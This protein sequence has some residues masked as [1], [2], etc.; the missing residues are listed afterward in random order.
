VTFDRRSLMKYLILV[1]VIVILI[2]PGICLNRS[3]NS[4]PSNDVI[5][6]DPNIVQEPSLEFDNGPQHPSTRAN[7]VDETPFSNDWVEAV[8]KIE[9]QEP[10]FV[11]VETTFA[12]YEINLGTVYGNVT[13]ADI[14]IWAGGDPSSTVITYL[15]SHVEKN[16][17]SKFLEITFPNGDYNYQSSVVSQSSLDAAEVDDYQPPIDLS[18]SGYVIIDEHAYFS[19]SELNEYNIT[20]VNELIEG[21]LKMGAKITQTLKLGAKAGHY[22]EFEISVPRYSLYQHPDQLTISHPKDEDKESDYLVVKRIDNKDGNQSEFEYLHDI[23]LRASN[24]TPALKTGVK[25]EVYIQLELDV[26]NFNE[27]YLRDSILEISVVDLREST[28]ELPQNITELYFMSSDGIRLFYE[29]GVI[30]E[31]DIQDEI[32][33]ELTKT[34]D[35]LEEKLNSTN[36]IDLE[37]VKRELLLQEELE[38]LNAYHRQVRKI[39]SPHLS[40]PEKM[41]LTEATRPI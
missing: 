12:V 23:V 1:Y 28:I 30:D 31:T 27:I 34:S 18:I 24:P 36:P 5:D 8:Y 37:L 9:Y 14:R 33:E 3:N 20:N 17:F 16:I 41:W 10:A 11:N 25:E 22:N 19:D 29:N 39:L 15:K 4:N 26:I 40:K 32:N 2:I 21:S 6:N 13:A 35:S 38:W 7:G